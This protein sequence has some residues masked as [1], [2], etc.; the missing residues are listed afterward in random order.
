MLNSF[1]QTDSIEIG[2]ETIK[3]FREAEIIRLESSSFLGFVGDVEL[4][5]PGTELDTSDFGM[6]EFLHEKEQLFLRTVRAKNYRK[7]WFA[8]RLLAKSIRL[9][10]ERKNSNNHKQ[11]NLSNLNYN[12]ICITSRDSS[13]R[14]MKPVMFIENKADESSFSI[15][16]IDSHAAVFFAKEKFLRIGCDLVEPNSITLNLQQRYYKQSEIESINSD[17]NQ[18]MKFHNERIWGVK[19][20]AF[21]I[22]GDN[23][24]FKPEQWLTSYIENGWYKCTDTNS[25]TQKTITVRTLIINNKI[26]TISVD[27]QS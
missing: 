1:L 12:Q 25:S 10:L 14:L 19:E 16:H 15:S 23:R 20:T 22:L 27:N 8:G 18:F 4:I 3:S 6:S 5:A 13:N 21:K 9:Q 26:L 7:S 2:T 24:T 11:K 17:Q